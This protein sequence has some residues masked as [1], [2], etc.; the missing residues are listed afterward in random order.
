MGEPPDA[1]LRRIALVDVVTLLVVSVVAGC[2]F[3]FLRGWEFGLGVLLGGALIAASQAALAV[4]SAKAEATSR[5]S[6][7]A[8]FAG[9]YVIKAGAILVVLLLAR[10]Y[11]GIDLRA[12]VCGVAGAIVVSL[13][14]ISAVILR[15]TPNDP[16][17]DV[18]PEAYPDDDDESWRD[19]RP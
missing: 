4:V 3:A 15:S 13:V 1:T 10:H 19:E 6:A 16:D 14:T 18:Y 2:L 9:G 12:V 17:V 7:G 5:L 11:L 8:V